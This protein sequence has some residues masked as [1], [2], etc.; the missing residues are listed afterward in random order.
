MNVA[1]VEEVT[2]GSRKRLIEL[3]DYVAAEDVAPPQVFFINVP[4]PLF[5]PPPTLFTLC[6]LSVW[7]I[8]GTC[9]VRAP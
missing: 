1:W 7:P 9:C 8:T 6:T 5:Q 2:K 4:L 3:L